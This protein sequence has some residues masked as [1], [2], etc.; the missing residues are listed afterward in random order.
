MAEN[1]ETENGSIFSWINN[2]LSLP[3]ANALVPINPSRIP[4]YWVGSVL[5]SDQKLERNDAMQPWENLESSLE[6]LSSSHND[7]HL[8]LI[9]KFRHLACHC[10]ASSES[11]PSTGIERN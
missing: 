8:N 4:S 9:P 7:T 11:W 5:T 3:T 6:Y 1:S 2:Y 10:A